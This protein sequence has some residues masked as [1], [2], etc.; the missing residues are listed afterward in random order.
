MK[1]IILLLFVAV[2]SKLNAQ[3]LDATFIEINKSESGYPMD[4]T[5]G[6]TKVYFSAVDGVHGREL[7]SYDLI[8]QDTK[9]IKDIRPGD[10]S[11]IDEE[12]EGESYFFTI[13]DILYF[14]AIYPSVS[15]WR[16]DGTEEGTFKL[17]DLTETNFSNNPIKS[18]AGYNG[19]LFFST[20]DEI[21]GFELWKS[22]GTAEN[23]LL[24]KDI[25]PGTAGSNISNM[26][27]FN[28]SLYFTAYT[29]QY[30]LELWK[31]DGTAEGTTLLKDI[32]P[33]SNSGITGQIIT[34]GN[35]FYF[36]ANDGINGFELW[37]S[38]GT[39]E[40][41]SLVKNVFTGSNGGITLLDGEAAGNYVLFKSGSLDGNYDL[42]KSD[43][44]TGGTIML[45][46]HD[47]ANGGINNFYEYV[48]LNG[49]TY[50]TAGNYNDSE[51]IWKTD[52]TTVG[53]ALV[54]DM[55]EQYNKKIDQITTTQN[56]LVF[57]ALGSPQTSIWSSNGTAA[58][59]FALNN[60]KKY[61]STAAD[62]HF[63]TVDGKVL[64]QAL[65]SDE[66]G[67]ELW[68][69][70]GTIENTKLIQDIYHR[71]A[72]FIGYGTTL[73]NKFIFAG[74][75][76]P[77]GFE[78]FVSDGTINGTHLLKDIAVATFGSANS[79][80]IEKYTFQDI[81]KRVGNTIYFTAFNNTY[82]RE[83]FKTD[84]TPENTVIVKDIAPGTGSSTP[85]YTYSME[86]NGILYFKA[87]DL[88]HGNELW[89]T[90]GTSEGTYMLKDIY[91]G[92]GSGITGSNFYKSDFTGYTVF[93][94]KLYFNAVDAT[95]NAV[96]QTDG[97]EAGT[98]KMY[99]GKYVLNST[100]SKLYLISIENNSTYGPNTLW[101]S[102]GDNTS[103]ALVGSW[104]DFASDQFKKNC[105][106]NDELYF[107]TTVLGTGNCIIKTNGTPQGTTIVSIFSNGTQFGFFDVCGDY[108]YY[109]GTTAIWK[110]DGTSEGTTLVN[111]NTLFFISKPACFDDKMF[112]TN[113][114]DRNT[115]WYSG[116]NEEN[117]GSVDLNFTNYSFASQYEGVNAIA[118]ITNNTI[119][120]EASSM[121]SG[122]E[123]LSAQLGPLADMD[124]HE[125]NIS[126]DEQF[127]VYPNPTNGTINITTV[128]NS[129]IRTAA[130]YDFTGKKILEKKIESVSGILELP[131]LS[132]GI[133]F[134]TLKTDTV[135]VTK[136]IIHN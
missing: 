52:G 12:N 28:D 9:L 25:N 75:N 24:L 96:W 124:N 34:M 33:L 62:L 87:D 116:N 44:T 29:P 22:G 48:S 60:L 70:D 38:D 85:E 112:Y 100:S 8:T 20:Y 109:G 74:N 71:Y 3:S 54:I 19:S 59:T 68:I 92:S 88:V 117:T 7:Y 18:M 115:L 104:S 30:G 57:S 95:G 122:T 125:E 123:L 89:R 14:K 58:G 97:T 127:I 106:L 32:Y 49:T 27:V 56:H 2:F 114:M 94:G 121:E 21:N 105:I 65:S 6:T 73:G 126:K 110:T 108:I 13:G 119:Y 81:F 84:G 47:T 26:L 130:V 31:S 103:P 136:K 1:K 5:K 61:N 17:I 51:A 91:S 23:T 78:P 134:L 129:V 15:L 98:V 16:S 131:Q 86:Y 80:N 76:G 36:S 113:T 42:W 67:S 53:T 120:F 41:T 63:E 55:Y 50:F 72:G 82:G 37:K 128:N 64:F 99:P 118:G 66:Y 35:N 39:A 102:T 11:G 69:T 40:G 4:I 101:S 90:D 133:Y 43:G 107:F 135:N 77:S 45:K 132:Q 83:L 93:N 111:G 79:I 10:S 46:P